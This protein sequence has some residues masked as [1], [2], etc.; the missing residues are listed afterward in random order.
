MNRVLFSWLLLITNSY[1][2]VQSTEASSRNN[3]ELA[4]MVGCP[5]GEICWPKC[6]KLDEYFDTES[7]ACTL[8]KSS[9]HLMQPDIYQ[10]SVNKDHNAELEL[11]PPKNYTTLE[12]YGYTLYSQLCNKSV[13]F[14]PATVTV[15]MLS[16]I[17]LYIKSLNEWKVY[18][19]SFCFENFVNATSGDQYLSAFTC[20]DANKPV[21]RNAAC[22]DILQNV[23]NFP[24]KLSF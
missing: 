7:A 24:E 6:C 16:D 18:S 17:K 14:Q 15:K 5:D 13:S 4:K 2:F 23:V 21:M 8:A 19:R 12:R 11:L 10:L 3:F 20:S 9:E 1:H 22:N